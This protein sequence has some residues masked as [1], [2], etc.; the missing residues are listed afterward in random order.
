MDLTSRLAEAI[1]QTRI[2]IEETDRPDL[3]D[4]LERGLEHLENGLAV[5]QEDGED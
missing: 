2:V 5:L 1:K 3:L 4:A